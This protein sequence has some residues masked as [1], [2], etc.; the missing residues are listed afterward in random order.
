[1]TADLT[2]TPLDIATKDTVTIRDIGT[3]VRDA[4]KAKELKQDALAREVGLR[5][6]SYIAH[7]ER[8]RSVPS[9][10]IAWKLER[11]LDLTPGTLGLPLLKYRL[12]EACMQ[13]L[14]DAAESGYRSNVKMMFHDG[15]LS[16]R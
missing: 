13:I 15:P 11:H 10:Q 2:H 1:M 4:R 5:G 16:R 7:I 9:F 14:R 8:G 12:Q 3:L 6:A